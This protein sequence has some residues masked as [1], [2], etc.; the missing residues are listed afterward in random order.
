MRIEEKT[1]KHWIENF[2]GYGSWDAR[3]WFVGYE[4]G[5]GDLPEEVA[6]KFNYFDN[7]MLKAH[8]RSATSATCIV[9][10]LFSQKDPERIYSRI[11]TSTASIAMLCC[12]ARGKIS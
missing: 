9:M 2:Y 6:E 12:M 4:E 7:N 5:G 1:L 11:F 10:F 3:I 8:Q